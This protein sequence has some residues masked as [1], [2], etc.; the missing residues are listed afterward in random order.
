LST[1]KQVASSDGLRPNCYFSITNST[2]IPPPAKQRSCWREFWICWTE[3]TY[4]SKCG[5]L[6]LSRERKPYL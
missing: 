4:V 3:V 6:C 2:C 5:N 1:E